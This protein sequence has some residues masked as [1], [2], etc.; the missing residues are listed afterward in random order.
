MTKTWPL[1]VNVDESRVLGVQA[2]RINEQVGFGE[3]AVYR[4][5]TLRTS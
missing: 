3:A 2:R 4:L 5:G 1:A